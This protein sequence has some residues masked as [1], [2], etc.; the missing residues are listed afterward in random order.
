MG[1]SVAAIICA[2]GRSRRFSGKRNKA[3]VDVAGRAVFLRS[4]ELFEERDDVKQIIKKE[5]HFIVSGDTDIVELGDTLKIKINEDEDYQ[6]VAGLMSYKLGR[7]PGQ[8]DKINLEDHTF[9]VIEIDKHRIKKVKIT[10]DKK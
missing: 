7:I 2:A 10:S 5:D 4:V 6:T 8:S 1:K 9:E 3:F